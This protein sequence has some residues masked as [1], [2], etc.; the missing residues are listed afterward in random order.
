[1]PE[2]SEDISAGVDFLGLDEEILRALDMARK[3]N[4]A[5]R[6]NNLDYAGNIFQ[7]VGH[8]NTS[9]F[10]RLIKL[11]TSK[12]G[13]EAWTVSSRYSQ[14]NELTCSSVHQTEQ[15]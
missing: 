13:D 5:V 3:A 2:N 14:C 11:G 8:V 10:L 12:S 6:N 15:N 4:L 7:K 1:M 9:G